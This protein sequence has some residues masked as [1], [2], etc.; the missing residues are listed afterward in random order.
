MQVISDPIV[1]FRSL[2]EYFV[3]IAAIEGTSVQPYSSP[4]LLLF[5]KLDS[6]RQEETIRL[7]SR[8]L[9]VFDETRAEG[10]RLKD[11]PQL[12]WR[13]LRRLK[14]TPKSDVFDRIS[15]TDVVEV[16]SSEYV[17]IFRNIQ[18][19]DKVSYPQWCPRKAGTPPRRT[20]SDWIRTGR[21]TAFVAVTE[22]G[23][24]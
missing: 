4:E 19:Y 15:D 6:T 11:T 1:K 9:E 17:G 2:L 18:F 24:P 14:M 3:K 22:A 16:Y 13:C 12:L 21:R 8:T 23:E 7:L 10:Y 20:C 5:Q